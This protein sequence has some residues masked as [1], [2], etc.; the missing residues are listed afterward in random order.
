MTGRVSR[1]R[2]FTLVELLMVMGIMAILLLAAGPMWN[3]LTRSTGLKGATMQLRTTL[4]L[5]RQWAITHRENT[6]VV[7]PNTTELAVDGK[8]IT[9]RVLRAY[10]V[11]TQTDGFIREWV[12]LPNGVIF[13]SK[14]S[15][16]TSDGQQQNVLHD[17]YAKSTI[18]YQ[19]P[20][21]NS[22]RQMS[23]LVFRPDGSTTGM[24][25]IWLQPKVILKEG[26]VD[27]ADPDGV[28][29]K[30]NSLTNT[31]QLSSMAGQIKVV[32]K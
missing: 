20:A 21:T 1:L 31:L 9:S 14:L 17:D 5:A 8:G 13:D 26:F 19:F 25:N 11:Y 30:A 12:F 6:Y 7:F 23:A 29:G 32:E 10:N 2:G 22:A 3:G 4:A 16:T 27:E 28:Q 15:D 18:L 24:G